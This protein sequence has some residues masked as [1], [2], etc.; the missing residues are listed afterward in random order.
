MVPRRTR[1]VTSLCWRLDGKVV[2][3]GLEDGTVLLHD[4]ETASGNFLAFEDRTTRFF[5][6]APKVPRMPGLVP[7]DAGLTDDG[8]DSFVELSNSSK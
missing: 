2:V 7:G 4:F 6:P 8:Q 3:L 1:S 5:P